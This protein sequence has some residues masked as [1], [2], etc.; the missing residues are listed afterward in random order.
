MADVK[1]A[2]NVIICIGRL[3]AYPNALVR[4]YLMIAKVQMDTPLFGKYATTNCAALQVQLKTKSLQVR[5]QSIRNIAFFSGDC[6]FPT[7]FQYP[8]N[9]PLIGGRYN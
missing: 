2:D 4:V 3:Y 5:L 7:I 1:H 8:R 9:I 6:C